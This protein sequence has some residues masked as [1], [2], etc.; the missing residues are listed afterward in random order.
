MEKQ[1]PWLASSEVKVAGFNEISAQISRIQRR[2]KLKLKGVEDSVYLDTK[3]QPLEGEAELGEAQIEFSKQ[4]YA[5]LS[6]HN[7]LMLFYFEL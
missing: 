2:K 6:I 1:T 7:C 4:G 3:E 5:V